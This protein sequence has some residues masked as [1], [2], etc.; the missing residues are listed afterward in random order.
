MSEH[1]AEPAKP[2]CGVCHG[3]PAK[4]RG[5]C[6]RC[7]RYL[8]RHGTDRPMERLHGRERGTIA[9]FDDAPADDTTTFA[10]WCRATGYTP[11]RRTY[12]KAG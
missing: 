1:A 8:L 11:Q 12:R 4:G 2:V 3:R 7:Y 10:E 6:E 9:Q 5:R